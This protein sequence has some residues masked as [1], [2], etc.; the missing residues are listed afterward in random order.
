MNH[1][2]RA[3][4]IKAALKLLEGV[5]LNRTIDPLFQSALESIARISF[6]TAHVYSPE[7]RRRLEESLKE[8]P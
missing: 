5:H 1:A 3:R 2:E 8:K 4:R 7:I 6:L